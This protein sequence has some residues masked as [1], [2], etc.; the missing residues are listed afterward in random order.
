MLAIKYRQNSRNSKAYVKIILITLVSVL[1]LFNEPILAQ[2]A[3]RRNRQSN[4]SSQKQ[5]QVTKSSP[6]PRR[7]SSSNAGRARTRSRVNS[8]PR[9]NTPQA[10]SNTPNLSRRSNRQ[11]TSQPSNR[12]LGNITANRQPNRSTTS[13]VTTSRPGTGPGTQNHPSNSV[14]TAGSAGASS[15]QGK[16]VTKSVSTRISSRRTSQIGSVVGNRKEPAS[17]TRNQSTVSLNL[18]TTRIRSSIGSVLGREKTNTSIDAEQSSAGT[19][20]KRT[21]T[22]RWSRIGSRII[23]R[24]SPAATESQT[25]GRRR[26]AGITKSEAVVKSTLDKKKP[27]TT[28][29]R[30]PRGILGRLGLS[31]RQK[32][33]D[34]EV[35]GESGATSRG[36]GRNRRRRGLVTGEPEG[37]R[38][39]RGISEVQPEG[40]ARA[41]RD[42]GRA[43]RADGIRPQRSVRGRPSRPRYHD[44]PQLVRHENSNVYV[45]RDRSAELRYRIVRPTS[46]YIVSYSR[47][48]DFTFGYIYPFYHR[49]YVFVSLGGYWPLGYSCARYYWYG[50]HPYY[51]C[52]YYPVAR[53]VQGDTYNYYTYNYYNDD[54]APV[55]SGQ[56]TDYIQPVDHSTFADVREKL[57]WQQ[58][59]GPDEPTLADSYF[60]N[61]VKAFEAGN[62]DIAVERFADAMEFAPDDMI[63][64]YAYCQALLANQQYSE[65]AEVLRSALKKINPEE[66][67]VFY[68]RGLYADDEVLFEQINQL[69]EK[70]DLL[71]FDTDLK[72]L[73]GYQLLGI[74]ELDEAVEPLLFASQDAVNADAAVTLI[75]LLE[76]IRNSEAE[77]EDVGTDNIPPAEGAIGK[78]HMIRLRESTFMATMFT[79]VTSG[80]IFYYVKC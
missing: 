33:D 48:W 68:P 34:A 51:W 28:P 18:Q 66:E 42:S 38:P 21:S 32:N 63:L 43:V 4:A 80:G 61:A 6:A 59:E 30:T 55:A 67:G 41:G 35:P 1:I 44:R 3:K 62:F 16:Q 36:A 74:G 19:T 47:G 79:L 25:S 70:A 13:S 53:E 52:G 39:R 57:A 20:N 56:S 31:K 45:Y 24:K 12:Q 14:G 50:W 27:A 17:T 26:S 78:G 65:A 7:Q 9:S 46:R 75:E 10:R 77:G 5:Q 69:N 60:E 58:A 22:T 15:G 64:P 71:S 73:L 54:S 2:K 49:K 8:T 72:L 23:D 40:T 76:K 29:T 37:T 11:T